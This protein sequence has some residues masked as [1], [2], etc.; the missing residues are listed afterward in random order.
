MADLHTFQSTIAH[1]LGL[2]V[3]TS[4][5]LTMDLN[6]EIITSN[7][8]EVSLFRLQ[9][10]WNL[11]TSGL[12]P[13]TYDWLVTAPELILSL[14]LSTDPTENVISLYRIVFTEPLLRNGLHNPVVPLLLDADDIEITASSIVACWTAYMQSCCLAMRWQIRYKMY[15]NT[16]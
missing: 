6:T 9:S 5:L 2:S 13:P 7:H 10:L 14:S 12:T 1:A 11:R 3:S 15:T 16:V 8:C 4:R